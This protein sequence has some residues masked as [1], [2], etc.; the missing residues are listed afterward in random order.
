MDV[1]G[2][3][4]TEGRRA[5][6]PRSGDPGR[7]VSS[8]LLDVLFAFEPDHRVLSLADLVRITGM[9]HATTRRFALE[10]VNAGALDRLADGRYAVGLRL[11]QVGTLAPN[12]ESLRTAAYPFL[13]DLNAALHQ[14]VQLAVLEDDRAVVIERLSAPHAVGLASRVGGR[15][16]LHCSGVGKVLLAHADPDLVDRV[17]GRPLRR[18]TPQTIL[19]AQTLRAELATC[20]RTGVS[21]VRSE[22]TPHA[23]SAAT[24]V[25]DAEG[26]VVAA[27]SVVVRAGSVELN[28]AVPSLIASGLG[29]SRRLGWRPGVAVRGG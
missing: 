10:L 17:L 27:M 18:Y 13:E 3:L 24:R 5:T 25:V 22:L 20:R 19:D 7:S 15:L 4:T 21:V 11:W 2:T 14:H 26:R 6:M 28:A 23:D 9:P 1:V 8:R 12:T 16:P 29:L